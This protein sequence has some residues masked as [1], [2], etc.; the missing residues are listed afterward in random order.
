MSVTPPAAPP[1]LK[2]LSTHFAFGRNWAS[3]STIIDDARVAQAEDGLAQ[4]LGR[5]GLAGKTFLDI[6]CGSGLHAV[7]AARL[8]AARS[9]ASVLR[10]CAASPAR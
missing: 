4:L 10:L 9:G 5:E 3:Y 8:G 6:G 1:A 7:A 2:D